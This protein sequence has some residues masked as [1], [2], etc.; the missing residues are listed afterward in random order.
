MI[1]NTINKNEIFTVIIVCYNNQ[2]LIYDCIDSIIN[3]DYPYIELIIADDN[4]ERINLDKI[5]QYI[6]KNKKENLKNIIIYKNIINLGTVKNINTAI[7]KANGNFIKIIAADDAL[8][9]KKV[10]SKVKK[11]LDKH[12]IIV[13]NTMICDKKLNNKK[14]NT[15]FP[16]YLVSKMTPEECFRKLCYSNIIDAQGIFMNKKFFDKY[17]D[18]DEE[19]LLLEDWPKWLQVTSEGCCF[20]YIPII[21]CKYRSD[22]GVYTS[23]NSKINLDLKKAH[24]KYIK[25][26]KNKLGIIEY[27]KGYLRLLIITSSIIRKIYNFIYK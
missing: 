23:I 6:N 7:K 4:S 27:S 24:Y 17:G 18:F 11:E 16:Q 9:S 10:L 14:I 20:G 1:N 12:E 22:N 13:S 5:K 25:P 21:T 26:Y 3:Q 15:K 19:F 8:F 2:N